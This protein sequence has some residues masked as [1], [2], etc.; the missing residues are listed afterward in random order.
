MTFNVLLYVLIAL[1]TVAVMEGFAWSMHR[2]VMHGRSGW[3]WHK[4]HHEETEGIFEKND[5]YAV[6]FSV[7]AVALFFV[8]QAL[9]PFILAIAW[10]ITLYGL[11]YF[12]VH[13][14][15][16][17]QRWPFRYV[18]HRGYAKR[19]V[20]AHRLH[21]AVEGRGHCVSFGFL[22][23]PPIDKLKQELRRSGVLDRERIERSVTAQG[24]V[25]APVR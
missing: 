3:A 5:L 18:P 10:G 17:H 8:G 13:D 19:L 4:S 22:Y 20:Q 9:S 12:I 6:V 21:H 1:A 14:G 11:L 7:M 25:H 24:S 15:L 16:V 23:A 2:F